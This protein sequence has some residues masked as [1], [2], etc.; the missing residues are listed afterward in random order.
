MKLSRDLLVVSA[1]L[2]ASGAFAAPRGIDDCEKIQAPM[3]YNECLASFGPTRGGGGGGG[4]AKSYSPANSPEHAGSKA[5]RRQDGPA[6]AG[7]TVRR[8][9]GGRIHVEFA[10]RH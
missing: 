4:G 7:A 3:A 2:A 9:P 5:H 8:G 10:P 1:L 6:L